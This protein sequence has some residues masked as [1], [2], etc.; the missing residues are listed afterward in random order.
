MYYAIRHVTRFHYSAPVSESI[1]EIRMQPRSDGFQR[2]VNFTLQTSPRSR[3]LAYRDDYGNYVHH[4]DVPGR[5]SHLTITAQALVNM[6]KPP[7]LPERLGEGAWAKLDTLVADD[8]YF[9]YMNPSTYVQPVPE[10]AMLSQDL[11]LR[12]GDDP[13]AMLRE[14]NTALY[15]YFEYAPQSTDIDTPIAE[16][17]LARRGVCQDFAHI[18]LGLLRNQGVPA[19]YVSGYLFHRTSDHDRSVTDSTHAWV[20][21]LLPDLG[22]VG[23][24]PTNNLIAGERHIRTAIGRDYADVPPTRGVFKGKATSSLEV[25]V[26]VTP[27]DAPPPTEEPQ[28]ISWVAAPSG[29]TAQEIQDQQQQQQQQ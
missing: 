16:A 9:D 22:W 12:R 3:V 6:E 2:S 24:D 19:R 13:L 17:I 21:A 8:A 15:D 20:E 11:G 18:M 23:F 28:V 25:A 26:H 14:L 10:L 4:F 1:T 5:H 27:S 7:A 29:M